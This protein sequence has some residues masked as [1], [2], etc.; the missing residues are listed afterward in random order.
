[1]KCFLPLIQA[2]ESFSIAVKET[3]YIRALMLQAALPAFVSPL[4]AASTAGSGIAWLY[5]TFK[6]QQLPTTLLLLRFIT[7]DR[8]L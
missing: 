8:Q 3:C 4:T 7:S 5:S 6:A 1:M 2:G